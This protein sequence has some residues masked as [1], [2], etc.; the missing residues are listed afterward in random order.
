MKEEICFEIHHGH[1]FLDASGNIFIIN[2]KTEMREYHIFFFLE[3]M[4]YVKHI[5][6]LRIYYIFTINYIYALIT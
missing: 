2:E 5:F 6:K 4:F 1:Y 3:E